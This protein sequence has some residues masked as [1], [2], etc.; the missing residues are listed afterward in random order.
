MLGLELI[1]GTVWKRGSLLNAL[2][3]LWAG[4]SLKASQLLPLLAAAAPTARGFGPAGLL[5]GL[6]PSQGSRISLLAGPLLC[7]A[8]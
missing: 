5:L 3:L 4:V 2:F 6:L 7:Q 8:T 1:R